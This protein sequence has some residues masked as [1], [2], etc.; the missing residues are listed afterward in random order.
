MV[1]MRIPYTGPLPLPRIVPPDAKSLN[2]AVNALVKFLTSNHDKTVLLTGAGISV[3][4][5]DDTYL[6]FHISMFL[7]PRLSHVQSC[8]MFKPLI[9]ITTVWIE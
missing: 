5:C 2:G 1:S 3:A 8:Q 6:R 9:S 4:V 7:G